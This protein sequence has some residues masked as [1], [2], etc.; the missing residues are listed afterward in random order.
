MIEPKI[1]KGTRDF[2][3]EEMAK[4]Q[5][6]MNIIR[7]VFERYGYDA[8]DTP[9]IE[10]AETILGKYGEEGDK[11]TYSFEDNGG[12]QIALR[13][14]QTV[15]FARYY[16]GNYGVL[17]APFK[18]YQISKVWRADK[19]QRGRYR[20]FVQC[21]ID[22]IG[23]QSLLAEYELVSVIR[24]VFDE[25]GLTEVM[26]KMN[27]R[28]LMDSIMDGIGIES[29]KRLDVIRA[30]DK[31][32]KIGPDGVAKEFEKL[33]LSD[34]EVEEL[35]VM[36]VRSGSN[37][38]RLD[39]FDGYFT[40]RIEK[41]LELAGDDRLHFDVSLARGLDYYT[42]LI[43]EVVY[44]DE[45]LGSIC[46]GGRYDNL[47]GAFS[48]KEF[49]G[50]GVAFGFER[51]MDLMEEE[52]LLD[53]VALNSQILV[54]AFDEDTVSE[55]LKVYDALH[56]AGVN[57]EIYFDPGTKL[58]KQFKYADRKGI[59]FAVIVG[60]DEIS[61]GVLVLKNLDSGDQEELNLSD[62]LK[63]NF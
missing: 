26:I 58:G 57:T 55:S 4:R 10:Y 23:T 60:P 18:R 8:I 51:I 27:D 40:E 34:T 32:E 44:G 21:D 43:F 5:Y 37:D 59:P 49:S 7:G 50:V 52:A 36:L 47:C 33:N 48:K 53:D 54:T 20:E 13:Y 22:I 63:K 2:G 62:L 14:D 31:L 28:A 39:R 46:A 24:D 42:G 29:S 19:P 56:E 61:K 35:K 6:V 16:A 38:E 41:M 12:R 17:A 15:P 25:L 11:L 3:P 30:I 45:S 1:L 9:V